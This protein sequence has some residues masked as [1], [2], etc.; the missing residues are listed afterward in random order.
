MALESTESK[1]RPNETDSSA[2]GPGVLDLL[3]DG[4]VTLTT[5]TLLSAHLTPTTTSTS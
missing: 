5:I 4:S 2:A 3:N 1:R